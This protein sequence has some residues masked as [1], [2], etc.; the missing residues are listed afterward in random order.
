MCVFFQLPVPF[1]SISHSGM[2][3]LV[4]HSA[5]CWVV[6]DSCGVTWLSLVSTLIPQ[7]LSRTTDP[8]I[9]CRFQGSATICTYILRV[10]VTCRDDDESHLAWS[11]L[12]MYHV[13][14][15]R[16]LCYDVYVQDLFHV[17]KDKIIQIQIPHIFWLSTLINL[18]YWFLTSLSLHQIK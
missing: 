9:K 18:S 5:G 3:S 4:L 17:S 10:I 7:W 8:Y 1:S 13:H 2:D 11:M 12:C 15:H 6:L 16:Y 14:I